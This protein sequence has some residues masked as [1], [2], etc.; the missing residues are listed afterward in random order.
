MSSLKKISERKIGN[1]RKS[2]CEKVRDLHGLP[3]LRLKTAE[4]KGGWAMKETTVG[5]SAVR[6]KFSSENEKED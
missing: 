2:S 3:S 5:S 6:K 4:K 1:L